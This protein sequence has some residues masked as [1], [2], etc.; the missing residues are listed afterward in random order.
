MFKYF[1]EI[2]QLLGDDRG[3]V[4]VLVSMFFVSSVFELL[5]ISLL[6]P[7][8]AI[9]VSPDALN[10]VFGDVVPY[11]GLPQNRDNLLVSMGYILISLFLLK[12]IMVIW[13][14]KSIIH[15]CLQQQASL[16]SLLMSSYQSMSYVKYMQRNSSEYIY[17]IEQLTHQYSAQVLIPLLR[18]A[19]DV[20]VGLLILALLAWQN[21]YALLLLVG[22]L[23]FTIVSY[24]LLFRRNLESYGE[25]SNKAA[26][27]IVQGIH[28]GMDGFKEVKIL[29]KEN[30]FY[31]MVCQGSQLYATYN[32]K[33]QI[34][35]TS[36]RYLL[37]LVLVT[38]VV[39]LIVITLSVGDDL[40]SLIP[41]LTMFGVAAVR[42][43]PSVNT[44]TSSLMQLRYSR[45]TVS[46][47]YHDHKNIDKDGVHNVK[48]DGAV[49][50]ERFNNLKLDNVSFTYPGAQCKSLINISLDI[51]PGDSIGFIGPSGS[52]KTTLVDLLLGLI[53]PQSGTV[54]FNDK[55]L[56]QQLPQ[57]FSQVAYLPQQIFLIDNTLR[58][59]IA[60]GVDSDE[61]D[62]DRINKAIIQ[63]QLSELVDKL[64]QGMNT[65]I[66]EKGIRLSG[67]Q[68]Q[69]I[70]L[71]RAFYHERNVLVMD[72][73]TSALD[74]ETENEIVNEIHKFKK[75][76]TIIVIA[77][78]LT[79]LK[80]C[81]CI[82]EIKDGQIVGQGS[83]Q[84]IIL[85]DKH[86]KTNKEHAE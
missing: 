29:G 80:N 28:E 63:A 9:I 52:G 34:F 32:T 58:S 16:R 65:P 36:P 17:S 30:F 45:D 83:Y 31:Q 55:N 3:K 48:Q 69:R 60:L 76:K 44:L 5:S 20:I 66:G 71:A 51:R 47:L 10:G 56:Y 61:I 77:H 18:T 15:F 73:A 82:Y 11:I 26:T 67:G 4:V 2:W 68:R 85:K 24:D 39:L 53:Q 1:S 70:A 41:T 14:N 12:T 86:I 25:K 6:G 79:T 37:E 59:N 22:L 7:Y 75:E 42:L 49:N 19:S 23:L 27:S 8:I 50:K 21:L 33:L 43:L 84:D 13:I 40:L 72:E 46:R 35:S 38:F 78:R 54:T 64:P 81:D 57:W 62:D 74:N